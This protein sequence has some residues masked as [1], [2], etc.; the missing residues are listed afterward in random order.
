MRRY[1]KKLSRF[2]LQLLAIPVT[3]I[4]HPILVAKAV[5]L[6]P[7]FCRGLKVSGKWPVFALG[8]SKPDWS[9]NPLWDYFAQNQ[10]GPGIWKW[11]HY[12]EAYDRHLSRFRGQPVNLLEIGIYS[13]GSLPMWIS[14][15]GD[16]CKVFGVDI[17]EACKAYEAEQIQV[18]IGDQADRDFWK[19]FRSSAPDIHVL[20]D[21]GGHTP[22]QQM[23]TLEEMLPHM[24]VGSVYVC[25]DIH[26]SSN[27]FAAFATAF[28]HRLNKMTFDG[29]PGIVSS[30]IQLAFHSIH[31]Y[32]FMCVIEKHRFPPER[33]IAPKHGTEWQPFL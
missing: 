16:Q 27:R 30:N 11:T 33:L 28:V 23:T 8:G 31:F 13:G 24:P 9:G 2:L 22:E 7:D 6:L 18:F 17:E 1:V 26:G 12:F 20:I 29:K 3:L 14:Y 32:P 4:C 10:N 15:F 21:D 25:E 5:Y 19:S